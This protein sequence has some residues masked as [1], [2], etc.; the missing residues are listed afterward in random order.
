[1]DTYSQALQNYNDGKE[2]FSYEIVRNDGY[3]SVV[4]LSVFFDDFSFTSIELLALDR[5]KGKIIDVGAGA[6]RHTLELQRR[7]ANVTAIDISKSAVT[8]MKSRGVKKIIH[9]DI[10]DLSDVKYDTL[11]MLMNGIGMVG[12]PENLD[13]FLIK[14]KQ[15]LSKN[16]IIIFDSVD[17]LKT[18]NQKHISYREKNIQNG[19][20]PGQQKLRINYSGVSGEW[21]NWLH[22]NFKEVSTVELVSEKENGQYVAEL[23]IES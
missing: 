19:K 4:P 1:M 18:D 9:S 5:C 3:S 8:V 14:A 7:N 12:S 20:L 10:M 6:G 15:L 17:V 23:Q 21:F 16:G 2:P 11:L 22:I 13:K